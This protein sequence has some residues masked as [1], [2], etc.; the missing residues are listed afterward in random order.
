MKSLILI[1]ALVNVL[2]ASWGSGPDTLWIP[3]KVNTGTIHLS[4]LQSGTPG[5]SIVFINNGFTVRCTKA[6]VVTWLDSLRAAKHAG[7]S[8]SAALLGGKNKAY[9]DTVGNG[10]LAASLGAK[11]DTSAHDTTGFGATYKAIKDTATNKLGLHAKADSSG[12][13]DNVKMTASATA[14]DSILVGK[15][16]LVK[17]RTKAQILADI[18]A[19]ATNDSRLS[20]ARTPLAHNQAWSTIT[21]TDTSYWTKGVKSAIGFFGHLF[22]Y[23]DS[24][25]KVPDTVYVPKGIKSLAGFFGHLFGLADTSTNTH[26]ADTALTAKRSVYADSSLSSKGSD[27]ARKI[28]NR[29]DVSGAAAARQAAYANLTSIGSLAN[30]AG[31]LNNNGSGTF[32][33]STPPGTWASN[34]GS[35][36]GTICQ[37]NDSRLSDSRAPNGSASGDLT[38]S[39]PGPTVAHTNT[40]TLLYGDSLNLHGTIIQKDGVM[41]INTLVNLGYLNIGGTGTMAW[42]QA[43]NAH[44]Y[45]DADPNGQIG[46]DSKYSSGIIENTARFKWGLSDV[47]TN[48]GGRFAVDIIDSTGNWQNAITAKGTGCVGIGTGATAPINRLHVQGISGKFAGIYLN[49]AAPGTATNTIYNYGGTLYWN[50]IAVGAQ[51]TTTLSGGGTA[52]TIPLWT[53]STV[54]GNSII[55]QNSGTIGVNTNIT[56]GNFNVGNTSQLIAWFRNDYAHAYTDADPNGRIGFDSKYS[57]GSISNVASIKYGLVDLYSNGGARF[58]LDILNPSGNWQNFL[59]AYGNGNIKIP[60]CDTIGGTVTSSIDSTQRLAINTGTG[61]EITSF[62]Q[63]G[64]P[65]L[66]T[67]ASQ[68]F[69]LF[70]GAGADLK[71]KTTTTETDNE[72]VCAG[73]YNSGNDTVVGVLNINKIHTVI[74]QKSFSKLKDTINMDNETTSYF[75]ITSSRSPDWSDT[76]YVV[77][78]INGDFVEIT[79][80]GN[81]H[82]TM[83]LDEGGCPIIKILLSTCSSPYGYYTLGLRK[84]SGYWKIVY[85]SAS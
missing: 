78:G 11:R 64:T 35:S 70:S 52:N 71:I 84:F 85:Y 41:K 65:S 76:L 42:L 2:F 33:Y 46:F 16:G 27:T 40:S 10:S 26:K 53:G 81:H 45:T 22:G 60:G 12:K 30:A 83:Y 31:W 68:W 4:S 25:A 43:T 9:F 32:A 56:T 21:S 57:S 59:T 8:D 44:A 5:D 75:E 49:D 36:A 19:C 80:R 82:M 66:E 20:D 74:T 3:Q 79:N 1:F 13:S 47:Y 34:F 18:G 15:D 6:Q 38:G 50:G 54:L 63:S 77:G 7:A 37:G 39:Y 58:G 23:S 62:S 55:T 69:Y 73:L 28:D 61:G 67:V 24:T 72:F 17:W 29:Y 48:N 14:S 51:Q